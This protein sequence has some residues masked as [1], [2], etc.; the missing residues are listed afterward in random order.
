MREAARL[1]RPVVTKPLDGNHGRGVS[2]SLQGEEA[3]REGFERAVAQT[4]RSRRVIVEE[5]LPGRDHR[6]LVVGGRVV[7]VAEREAAAVVGDGMRSVAALIEDTNKDPRRGDGHETVMTR[8]VIDDQVRGRLARDG[9]SLDSVPKAGQTVWLRDTANL[10]TGGSAIDR[11][12]EI[13]PDN[14]AI[15]EQAAAAIGLDVAGI[16]FISPDIAKS[17]RETGGGIVE[18]NAA[19]GLRMH[20]QPARGRARHVAR[21]ILRQLFPPNA[22]SRIPVIAI[23]GTNGKSTTVRMV[24]A[25]MQRAGM[26]VGMTT[27]SGV[28]FNGRQMMTSDA[29]GPRSARMVLRNPLVDVAVLETARGGILREGLGFDSCDVG[30]V[31]NVSED[32]IGLKGVDSLEA[33]ARVKSVVVES[34]SRRGCSVLNADDPLTLRMAAHARGRLAYFSLRGGDQMPG[35]LQQHVVAGGLAVMSEPINGREEIVIYR[36]PE[37]ERLIALD[38][39]PS[40]L[41]G[42]AEFNVQNALAAAAISLGQGIDMARVREGL[43]NF[44]ISYENSPGRLNVHDG[45]PFR[46][47]LDYAHNPAAL[48]AL[49]KLLSRLRERHGRVIGMVSI[50]GDRRDEDILQMGRISAGVFDEVIFRETPDGRGRT[51]GAIN[52]L[53]SQGALEAGMAPSCIHRIIDEIAATDACLRL[54]EPGDIVVLLPTS[55]EA[56]WRR[57]QAFSYSEARRTTADSAGIGQRP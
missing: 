14:A 11:T 7:A 42:A 15:A 30:A 13:H 21:P 50:P 54:A 37:R 41:G 49:G 55:V 34:V 52:S 16:D 56:V 31:L 4:K 32:H 48:M 1:G 26:N 2:T 35:F 25:I 19:P 38:D 9:L 6:I 51:Q 27:T 17:V 3:V 24:A 22:P 10:S 36:G 8:I 57:A 23:T 46:V 28:Y 40:T 29:S 18:V 47:I 39:V 53:L 45:H 44:A 43:A 5:M 33:L 20:L 12:D